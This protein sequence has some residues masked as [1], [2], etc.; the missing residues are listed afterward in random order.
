MWVSNGCAYSNVPLDLR[1]NLAKARDEW[2]ES[3]EGKSCT[4]GSSI[5]LPTGQSQYLRNR[6]EMAFIA[7]AEAQRRIHEPDNERQ[8]EETKGSQS[9]ECWDEGT[10]ERTV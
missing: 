3:K 10:W 8:E 5:Y 2:L 9:K 6:I 4:D 7:G 1:N